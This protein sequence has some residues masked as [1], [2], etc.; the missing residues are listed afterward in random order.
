MTILDIRPQEDCVDGDL[1]KEVV[2]DRPIDESFIRYLE[3]A[4]ALQY[5]S[6]FARP[7]FRVDAPEGFVLKGI[8]GR[9]TCQLITNKTDPDGCVQRVRW[10]VE[11]FA[12]QATEPSETD[13]R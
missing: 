13:K 9:K 5:F 2:F 11:S 1:Q 10:I 8:Q 3:N 7:F 12:D 4:G 6:D